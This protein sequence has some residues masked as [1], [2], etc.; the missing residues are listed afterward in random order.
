MEV[1]GPLMWVFLMCYIFGHIITSHSSGFIEATSLTQSEALEIEKKLETF[2][3]PAVKIIKTIYGELYGCVDFF[4]QPAFDHPSMKNHKYHYKMRPIWQPE[5]MRKRKI[6][7]TG[8]GYLWENGVGCPIGTVPIKRVTKFDILGSNLLE[9]QY[10]P[11]GSWDTT[12]NDSNNVVHYNQHHYAVGRT[13]DIGIHYHG[14][15]MD[16]SI[17]APKVKPTQ[18]S[19]S[20]LHIQIGDDFIQAGFTVN[21]VLYKDHQ[22]RTFVYTKSGGK[23]CYNSHCDVGMVNVRQDFPMG[24]AMKPVSVR[25]APISHY[26]IFGVIKDQA[27]GN[28]WLQF[29]NDAEEVGFWPSSRFRQSFGNKVEWGGE[30]Y[31]ASL[32]SPEMGQGFRPIK[33]LDYDAYAK[34]ISIL[35]GNYR[36]DWKVNYIEEFTDNSEGYDV[37]GV[38][39]SKVA[40]K[41]HIIFFG[42]SGGI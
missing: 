14:A 15:T 35:D 11:R 1:R 6:N 18:F 2:N 3:K 37:K 9:D 4:K 31:S 22:P 30:V 26:G 21:P 33:R 29:G 27:N 39:E 10:K 36:V 41:G 7:N 16:L 20:R 23:S 19:S 28:W 25:G 42:G 8:F 40:N 17:T 34:R 24:L 5:G 32:P 12:T 38:L 13:R